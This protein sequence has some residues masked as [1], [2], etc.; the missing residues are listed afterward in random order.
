MRILVTN[1]DGISS[2]GLWQAAASLIE[3][4]QVV[5]VAPDREQSG[6]GTSVSLL[7]PV[8]A[9]EINPPLEGVRS[10]A[11]EGTPGDAVILGLE[12]LAGGPVD[13]VVSGINAGANLGADVLVSGTV[14]AALQGFF[15]GVPSLAVSLCA[16]E[17]LHLESAGR[18]VRL[19]VERLRQSSLP[20]PSLL[21]VNIPNLPLDQIQGLEVTRLGSRA[22]ADSVREGDEGRRKL[23]WISRNR[24]VWEMIEGTDIW[25]VHNNRVSLTPLQI[26]LTGHQEL[27]EMRHLAQALAQDIRPD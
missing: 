8:R 23:Y 2:P 22:Y 11:V 25:A 7:T 26:D 24:P 15:R 18:L 17:N 14:G 5:V 3:L 19:L 10:F 13:L 9:R 1:D 27:A 16:V 4:G 6:T 21:N 12:S 20:R